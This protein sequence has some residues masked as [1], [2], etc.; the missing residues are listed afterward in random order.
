MTTVVKTEGLRIFVAPMITA[1]EFI[2][3]SDGERYELS[4]LAIVDR[5]GNVCL[6]QLKSNECLVEPGVIYATTN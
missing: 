2:V 6:S 1:P 4:R 3:T 5:A